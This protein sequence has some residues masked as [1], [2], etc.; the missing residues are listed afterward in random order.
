LLAPLRTP[1]II[2]IVYHVFTRTS[3]FTDGFSSVR[4]SPTRL[5]VPNYASQAQPR[6]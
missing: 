1:R 5:A 4:P 2:R 6:A 3:L